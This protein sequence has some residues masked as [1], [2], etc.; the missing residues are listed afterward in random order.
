M[1]LSACQLDLIEEVRTRPN[2]SIEALVERFCMTLAN[3]NEQQE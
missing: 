3:R 1:I 2:V